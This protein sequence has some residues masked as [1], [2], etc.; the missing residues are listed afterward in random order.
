M[1]NELQYVETNNWLVP[2][3][4]AIDCLIVIFL[5]GLIYLVN[6]SEYL[7]PFS[8][9]FFCEDL[10]IRM[11]LPN[12]EIAP[13][14]TLYTITLLVP[15]VMVVIGETC[16]ALKPN[17]KHQLS[18]Y[19]KKTIR[20]CN[21]YLT[22]VIRRVIRF[23]G[24]GLVGG[25]ITW[26]VTVS[27]QLVTGQLA[28]YFISACQ[29]DWSLVNCSA[30]VSKYNCSS[31]ADTDLLRKARMSFPSIHASM[32]AYSSV[33]VLIYLSTVGR[34]RYSRLFSPVIGCGC[35]SVAFLLCAS[36]VSSYMNHVSDVIAGFLLGASVAGYV[37]MSVLRSF[38][39]NS[40]GYSYAGE[41]IFSFPTMRLP[42]A[43]ISPTVPP[44]IPTNDAPAY[45]SP[46]YALYGI[47]WRER[48]F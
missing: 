28:P 39:E 6:Y 17:S 36:R 1:D 5:A 14:Y 12:D 38:F 23:T 25:L 41:E 43:N 30:F 42:R 20:S 27:L 3:F 45:M 46:S 18:V 47:Q 21:I 15:V 48:F 2:C 34:I 40:D 13:E 22:I 32:C 9:G 35:V 31:S 44:T 19:G 26:L 33:F 11:P 8:A 37:S 10:S 4:V 29:P 16:I 24:T 7:E